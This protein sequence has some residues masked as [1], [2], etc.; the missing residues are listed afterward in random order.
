MTNFN[1]YSLREEKAKS[2][3]TNCKT[4]QQILPVK[5][6]PL[7]TAELFHFH[8][9]II[10]D[11]RKFINASLINPVSGY[12]RDEETEISAGIG[13]R[14]PSD[15]SP[16]YEQAVKKCKWILSHNPTIELDT[17][18]WDAW[19][20]ARPTATTHPCT[21]SNSATAWLVSKEKRVEIRFWK[22]I[23]KWNH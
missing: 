19:E 2:V 11:S 1:H 17:T 4:R 3:G 15:Y 20:V 6:N 12:T 13:G 8:I 9:G 23:L 10:S 21:K 14:L 22:E 18:F 16:A 7:N 5:Y